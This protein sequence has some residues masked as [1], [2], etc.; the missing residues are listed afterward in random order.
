[1]KTFE[2]YTGAE[3]GKV[4]TFINQSGNITI[5]ILLDKIYSLEYFDDETEQERTSDFHFEYGKGE[6][7]TKAIF[8]INNYISNNF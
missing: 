5:E 2:T 4:G 1:M 3:K 6:N 8:E 7:A